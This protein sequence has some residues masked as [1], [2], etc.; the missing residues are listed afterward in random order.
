MIIK[1]DSKG[2]GDERFQERIFR[3]Q[4]SSVLWYDPRLDVTNT[5]LAA[6]NDPTWIKHCQDKAMG[7]NAPQGP[8]PL[9]GPQVPPPPGDK[10]K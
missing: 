10:P 1:V 3:A 9:P 6:L 2:W 4:V 8:Q 7:K 5:I